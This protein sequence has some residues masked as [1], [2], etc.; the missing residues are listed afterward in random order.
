MPWLVDTNILIRE[1]LPDSREVHEEWR[2]LLV[3]YTIVGAQVHDTRLVAAMLVHE[4]PNLLTFNADHFR[5][6]P[7]ITVA[8]PQE[9][10]APTG[11]A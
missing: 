1:L 2:R 4:V 5:R 9:I 8:L 7:D 6:F 10:Q 11:P 3:A